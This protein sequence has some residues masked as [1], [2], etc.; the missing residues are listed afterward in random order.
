VNF[1]LENGPAGVLGAEYSGKGA[2]SLSVLFL[3]VIGSGRCCEFE[4]GPTNLGKST[5]Y[6]LAKNIGLFQAVLTSQRH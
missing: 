6:S 3:V 1:D 5:H 2:S 4:I